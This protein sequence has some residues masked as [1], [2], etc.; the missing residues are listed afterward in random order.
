MAENISTNKKDYSSARKLILNQRVEL[1]ATG[2]NNDVNPIAIIDTDFGFVFANNSFLEIFQFP[3]EELKSR[4][5]EELFNNTDGHSRIVEILPKVE[6]ATWRSEV[7]CSRKDKT[8]FNSRL[9]V[10]LIKDSTGLLCGYEIKAMYIEET[11][12]NFRKLFEF[13]LRLE[14]SFNAF[15]DL[16]IITDQR[17]NIIEIRYL[18][19]ESDYFVFKPEENTKLEDALPRDI[20]DEIELAMNKV[21]TGP[22]TIYHEILFTIN[23]SDKIFE[24]KIT[25][26]TPN[27]F[28]INLRDITKFKSEN[29]GFK[30]TRDKIPFSIGYKIDKTGMSMINE[31]IQGD[32]I[33]TKDGRLLSLEESYSPVIDENNRV[34]GFIARDK[35]PAHETKADEQLL[36][37]DKKFNSVWLKSFD[38]MR[39]TDSKGNIVAVNPAFC[40]MFEVDEGQLIGKPFTIVYQQDQSGNERRSTRYKDNF[41]SKKFDI[42]RYTKSILHNG[43]SLFLLVN[44]S[45]LEFTMGEPLVL[46]VFRDITELKKV[47]DELDRAENLAAIGRMSSYLSHEI[48][49][50]LASIRNYVD[51]LLNNQEMPENTKPVLNILRDSLG[52]L[53]RL[54]NNVLL[55]SSNIR[56]IKIDLNIYDL[57]EKVKELLHHKIK[58]K[59]ILLKNNLTRN[60]LKGDYVS[61]Q[62]VFFNMIENAVDAVA[63]GGIIE[64]NDSIKSENYLVYITDNGCGINEPDK[65]FE[66][67]HSEK[68]GGTGLGLAIAKKIMELHDGN[69]TLIKTKPGETIFELSFPSLIKG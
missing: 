51:V 6:E 60:I 47:Q 34:V 55:F 41:E 23:N 50:P 68:K 18:D 9:N 25:R 5:F 8:T 27:Q 29:R 38:G 3:L 67:F 39:L 56:L 69:I 30:R 26:I 49:N 22:Q 62:S 63:N 43:K 20:V 33:K 13:L 14:K 2:Y 54:L 17:R 19:I 66:A 16:L 58:R 24:A 52:N 35:E 48:K 46:G 1:L 61:L 59:N 53:S 65:I 11:R 10:S 21:K 40:Q 57:V 12:P 42:Q 64:I 7:V 4:N 37:S 32:S 28:N 44:Y 15:P 31:N 45:Y 36:N